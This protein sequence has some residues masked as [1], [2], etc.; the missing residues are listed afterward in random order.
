VEE[1]FC[2]GSIL[3]VT[4]NRSRTYK[5]AADALSLRIFTLHASTPSALDTA[6]ATAVERGADGLIV[7]Q[8]AFFANRL[9]QLV[10]LAARYRIPTAYP[11]RETVDEG[12]L[13]S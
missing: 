7:G 8:D 4:S 2:T 12:G 6:F 5:K 11:H 1:N 3:K 9:K 10:A 13:I